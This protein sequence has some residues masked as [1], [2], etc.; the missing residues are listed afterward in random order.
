MEVVDVVDVVDVQYVLRTVIA[1]MACQFSSILPQA[2]EGQP[3]YFWRAAVR[4]E[5]Y[6]RLGWAR[7]SNW[8]SV[9]ER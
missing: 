9:P 3:C 2:T 7:A 5:G 1:T 6:D 4:R 8:K